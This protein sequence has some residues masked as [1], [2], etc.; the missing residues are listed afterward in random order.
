MFLL[1]CRNYE[2][3]LS[4]LEKCSINIRNAQTNYQD[5]L[6]LSYTQP[7]H[8]SIYVLEQI[9]ALVSVS[10]SDNPYLYCF[11]KNASL[12]VSSK[13]EKD[14]LITKATKLVEEI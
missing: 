3:R 10:S 11:F 12:D 5:G 1:H 6:S 14:Y 7:K 9:D 4:R 13:T 8:I 2:D